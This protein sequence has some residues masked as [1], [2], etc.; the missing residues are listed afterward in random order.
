MTGL[1]GLAAWL[2]VLLGGAEIVRIRRERVAEAAQIREEEALRRASEER[3]RIAQGSTTH[4]A[5]IS[6]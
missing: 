6:P 2:L 3:L 1:A 4:S 5:T